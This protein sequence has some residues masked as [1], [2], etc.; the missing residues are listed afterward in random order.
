[1]VPLP[2]H[3]SATSCIGHSEN[4]DP[5]SNSHVPNT[6][7]VYSINKITFFCCII[8]QLIST[9]SLSIEN[10]SNS[11]GRLRFSKILFFA[12][13][14]KCYH[15]KHVLSVVF[16]EVAGSLHSFTRKYLPNTHV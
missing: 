12:R 5:L 10:L 2:M 1:M 15:W 13:K 7:T 14:L 6:S 4:D 3:D 8:S 16:I 11:S 9:D